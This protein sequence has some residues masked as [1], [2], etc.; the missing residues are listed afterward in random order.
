MFETVV[1]ATDGSESADAAMPY[2]KSLA[3]RDG[4]TLVV[5]HAVEHML[6]SRAHGYP[7]HVDEDQLKA[8][9]ERQRA[10]LKEAGIDVSSREVGGAS[11]ARLSASVL[12][13]A[14]VGAGWIGLEVAAAA[15]DAGSR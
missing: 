13:V 15:R 2:A 10:E 9:I 6:G 3:Q 11:C 14:I 8:K 12:L 1:W 4:A 5:A 7:V